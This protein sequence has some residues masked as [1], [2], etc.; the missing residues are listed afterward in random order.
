VPKEIHAFLTET[1]REYAPSHATI[2]NCVA[3]FTLDDFSTCGT[4]RP[5]RLKTVN[6]PDKIDDIHELILEDP[7]PDFS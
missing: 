5:G 6:T 1:L 7:Q 3:Q 2:R 4:P